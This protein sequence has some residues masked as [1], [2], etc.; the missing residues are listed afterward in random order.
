MLNHNEILEQYLKAQGPDGLKDVLEALLEKSK[1]D[2]VFATEAHYILYRLGG[3]QS[4]MKVDMSRPPFQFWYYDLLGRPMTKMVERTIVDFLWEKC[5]EK[6]R[7][8]N[9]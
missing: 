1:Q 5:G 8:D 4:L 9:L 3:Q 6:E 2:P 7:S